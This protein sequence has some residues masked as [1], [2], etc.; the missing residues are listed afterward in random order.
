MSKSLSVYILLPMDHYNELLKTAM[1]S[2]I[3]PVS[4]RARSKALI[5]EKN[6][7]F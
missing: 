3:I 7:D 6:L 2:Y 1:I 4:I 5:E